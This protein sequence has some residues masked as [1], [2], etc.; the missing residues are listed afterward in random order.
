MSE[1]ND[2]AASEGTRDP[3]SWDMAAILVIM[4]VAFGALWRG[5]LAS[6]LAHN[7]LGILGVFVLLFWML[8]SPPPSERTTRRLLSV[9]IAVFAMM[10]VTQ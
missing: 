10:M 3:L 5:G 7:A 9:A 6:T 1:S 8:K 4:A 2:P